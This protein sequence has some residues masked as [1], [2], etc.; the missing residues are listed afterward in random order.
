M[1]MSGN[2][3][4]QCVGGYNFNYSSFNGLNGDGTIT[5]AGLFNTANWPTA[6]GGQA[7]GIARG[8][9]FAST[10]PNELRLSDRNWMTQNW[11]QVKN[12]AGGGRGVRIP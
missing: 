10:A 3:F 9:F 12:S 4:E 8:G 11:N 5:A 1:E 6:G 7:G 2:V